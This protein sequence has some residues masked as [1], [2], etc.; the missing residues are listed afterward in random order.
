MAVKPEE[1]KAALVEKAVA[2]V[3]ERLS[4]PQVD[5]AVRADASNSSMRGVFTIE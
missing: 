4:E 2:H 3:R 5:D 1:A